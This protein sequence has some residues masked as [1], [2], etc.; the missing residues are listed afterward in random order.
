M[1][2]IFPSSLTAPTAV[3]VTDARLAGATRFIVNH[4]VFAD[5]AALTGV[6]RTSPA[7]ADRLRQILDTDL[8]DGALVAEALLRAARRANPTGVTLF[9]STSPNR[10]RGNADAGSRPPLTDTQH[11]AVL[12]ILAGRDDAAG[13]PAAAGGPVGD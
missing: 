7:S 11:R 5:A 1:K 4:G 13:A 10:I 12:E 2:Q 8:P 3:P 6:L 9:S